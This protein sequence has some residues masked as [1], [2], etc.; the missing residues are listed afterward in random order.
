MS[1]IYAFFNPTPHVVKV[2]GWCT[3]EFLW[4]VRGVP[5]SRFATTWI[6][7]THALL[8]YNMHKHARRCWGDETLEVADLAKSVNEICDRIVRSILRNGS[9][10]TAFKH[11]TKGK[12]TYSH[13]QHTR[14]KTRCVFLFQI[15]FWSEL[16]LTEQRSFVGFLRTCAHLILSMTGHSGHSWRWGAQNITYH[17]RRLFCMMWNWYLHAHESISQRCWMSA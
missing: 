2:D 8:R 12:I 4:S 1:P 7:K 9:I 3:H 16:F 17:Q 11:N 13:R 6:S 10:T 14:A 15:H 5:R